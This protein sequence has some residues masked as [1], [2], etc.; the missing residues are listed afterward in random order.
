MRRT[1]LSVLLAA[2]ALCALSGVQAKDVKLEYKF[3][4]G[5][6]DKYKVTMGIWAS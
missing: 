1:A 5:E 3:R 4:K 2:F 6:V